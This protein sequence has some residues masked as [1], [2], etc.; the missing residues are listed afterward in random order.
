MP[1]P[2][3]GFLLCGFLPLAS[4]LKASLL[5]SPPE[6]YSPHEMNKML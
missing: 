6:K 4:F 1:V 5:L 3:A 2:L